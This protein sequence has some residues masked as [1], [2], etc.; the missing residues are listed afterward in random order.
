[1][2]GTKASFNLTEEHKSPAS[3]NPEFTELETS[4]SSDVDITFITMDQ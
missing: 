2:F 1:M 4:L 3:A